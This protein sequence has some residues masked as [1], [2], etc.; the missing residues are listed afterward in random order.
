MEGWHYF[1][2]KEFTWECLSDWIYFERWFKYE[3]NIT[4]T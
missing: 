4:D 3:Y 1:V 2:L